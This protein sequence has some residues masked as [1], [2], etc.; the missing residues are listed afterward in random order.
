MSSLDS[1]QNSNSRHFQTRQRLFQCSLS[2]GS[3]G[4]S[5]RIGFARPPP[6][7]LGRES[8]YRL[9]LTPPR[10]RMFLGCILLEFTRRSL[11]S[12]SSKKLFLASCQEK[13]FL[14]P[15]HHLATK[16]PTALR[17]RI[18]IAAQLPATRLTECHRRQQRG[19]PV[20]PTVAHAPK[21]PK[22]SRISY[23]WVLD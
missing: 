22:V 4:A 13:V 12:M 1:R 18:H 17:R 11:G 19:E 20:S 3:G 15:S 9:S 2:I 6:T 14:L 8:A 16:Y 7:D 10:I 5:K 21:P 23:S